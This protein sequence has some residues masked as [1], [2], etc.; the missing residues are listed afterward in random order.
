MVPF[1][2]FW[3][4]GTM[5]LATLKDGSR[6]GQLV[7][8]SRDLATA[9]FATG[10]ATRLQQVLDDWNYLAPLL[11]DLSHALNHGKARHAFDFEPRLAMAPLPRAVGW[12]D[13]AASLAPVERRQAAADRAPP[14]RLR[15]EPLMWPV[16]A[17]DLS[18]PQDDVELPHGHETVDFEA[19]LAAVTG[20]VERGTGPAQALEAVRLLGLACQWVL[21]EAAQAEAERGAGPWLGRVAS[22]LSPVLVTPEELGTQWQGGRVHGTLEVRWN[23]RVVGRCE[24][25]DALHFHLGQCVAQA[26]RHRR[27]RAGTLVGTGGLGQA[28][29]APGYCSVADARAIEQALHGQPATGWPR[30]GDRLRVALQGAQG[31][32]PLGAIAQTVQAA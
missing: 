19:G 4:P 6:D 17:G 29:A 23:D 20:D 30:A 12:I 2:A 27:L 11:E 7:V 32:E 21:P 8:V 22:A 31:D 10:I 15:S 1:P 16:M 3:F 14:P 26:A 25:A 18:G 24:A 28:D 13:T 5:K 9:H